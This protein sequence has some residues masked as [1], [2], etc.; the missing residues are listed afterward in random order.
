[1][2]AGLILLCLAYVLSQFYRAFLAVL[3]AV[4]ARDIG[5]G[6]EDLAF[7]SGLWFLAFAG[8]QL[9]I[10]WALDRFGPR[11]TSAIMLLIGGAGGALVF[12]FAQGAAHVNLAMLMIG[13]GCA[14][15]LVSAYF[16]LARQGSPAQFA[17]MAALLL[18][19]G[20]LGNLGASWPMA[21]AVEAIG[22]RASMIGLAAIT[23]LAA[24][25]LLI[26][27]RDP[28][29]APGGRRGSVMDLLKMR[30]LWPIFPMMFV[31]YAPVAAIRGLWIGPYLS[32]VFGLGTAQLGQASLVMGIAMIGGT[33]I[34]GPLDRI[35][36]THKWVIFSG[37]MAC[38][39][40]SL[41][42][43]MVVGHSV[44]L[45]IALCAAI[46]LFGSTFPVMIAHARGFFPA[47]LAGRGVTLMNLFGIGGVGLM[48]LGSGV[49]HARVAAS[50]GDVASYAALFA[51]FGIA[52]L[53]GSLVYLF[54]RDAP[55]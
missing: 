26:F 18:A 10:G 48:Q 32:D 4:L 49:I 3:G 8:A 27:V 16:I 47:H 11:R 14:P 33:L 29:A 25:V 6:P 43:A 39:A 53:A 37:N 34:Y 1:M 36:G 28:E 22:W 41:A 50:S 45:G 51:F 15:V 35:F 2:R 44:G 17:T 9:P 23:A 54:S 46:G 55:R 21:W 31:C 12:G 52:A 13:A 24:M 20:S 30:A 5:T 7:A 19:I 40:A 38:A 42:L